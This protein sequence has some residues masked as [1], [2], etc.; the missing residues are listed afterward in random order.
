MLIF[1]DINRNTVLSKKAI[2]PRAPIPFTI[3]IATYLPE[4][5]LKID[6]DNAVTFYTK[7]IMHDPDFDRISEALSKSPETFTRSIDFFQVGFNIMHEDIKFGSIYGNV[8]FTTNKEPV[9]D[10][11]NDNLKMEITLASIKLTRLGLLFANSKKN[12]KPF[13]ESLINFKERVKQMH[14]ESKL[15]ESP[16]ADPMLVQCIKELYLQ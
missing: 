4:S 3:N 16:E 10:L 9:Y 7:L 15:L 6:E 11:I 2:F 5:L 1:R 13:L 8:R 12:G 14:V